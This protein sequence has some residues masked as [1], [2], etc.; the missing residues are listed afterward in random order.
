M[1]YPILLKSFV[2]ALFLTGLSRLCGCTI[3]I[4]E[5]NCFPGQYLVFQ[6]EWQCLNAE[7]F[8][9]PTE[10]CRDEKKILVLQDD[11]LWTCVDPPIDVLIALEPYTQLNPPRR[12]AISSILEVGFMSEDPATLIR[13][14]SSQADLVSI[15]LFSIE[16][17]PAAL[18][19]TKWGGA[20]G[21]FSDV[22][23]CNEYIRQ[24]ADIFVSDFQRAKS[25]AAAI[26]MA[27]NVK[28]LFTL[29]AQTLKF[30]APLSCETICWSQVDCVQLSSFIQEVER[31]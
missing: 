2:Y 28:R 31:T 19:I 29:D 16:N 13:N 17:L 26:E 7:D 30:V 10:L 4:P 14:I 9:E 15:A 23:S 3:D 20:K 5:N 24:N 25:G 12:E 27:F 6:N 18:F 8:G 22:S 21:R 11:G 1:T